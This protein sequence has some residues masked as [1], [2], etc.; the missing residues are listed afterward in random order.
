MEEQEI[1][2]RMDFLVAKWKGKPES[3]HG[4]MEYVH[5]G[6]DRIIYRKLEDRL[7]K[8]SYLKKN[9]EKNDGDIVAIAKEI[10]DVD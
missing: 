10:F 7:K 6:I 1:K 3:Q 9:P 5:R 8:L 4:T 2:K